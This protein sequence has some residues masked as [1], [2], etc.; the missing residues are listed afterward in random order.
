MKFDNT[1]VKVVNL[2]E[3]E[4]DV[5]I[6]MFQRREQGVVKKGVTT[7]FRVWEVRWRV[8]RRQVVITNEV[9]YHSREAWIS[10]IAAY[11]ASKPVLHAD[12][13]E[14]AKAWC[15]KTSFERPSQY[16]RLSFKEKSE[17]IYTS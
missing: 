6:E 11:C 3:D 7:V 1:V 8:S 5:E 4:L 10:F 15:R 17:R 14:F 16:T 2:S 13:M 9:A 12:I